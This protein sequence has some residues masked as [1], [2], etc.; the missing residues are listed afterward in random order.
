MEPMPINILDWLTT[1][2]GIGIA[3]FAL[4]IS[5]LLAAGYSLRKAAVDKSAPE[6]IQTLLQNT[7]CDLTQIRSLLA[8]NKKLKAIQ[9][10]F[11]TDRISL[12]EA[13]DLVDEIERTMAFQ[14]NIQKDTPSASL[15]IEEAIPPNLEA[16]C[17]QLVQ[18]KRPLAAIKY[19]SERTG[20]GLEEAKSFI[21]ALV[22]RHSS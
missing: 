10:V 1:L 5:L 17:I 21:D 6:K 13:K 22:K 18:Q 7:Q 16:E 14:R 12:S 19:Y 8:Q 3:A 9:L 2:P 11:Q 4:F 20:C 15:K